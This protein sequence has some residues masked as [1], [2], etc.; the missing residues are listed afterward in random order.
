MWNMIKYSGKYYMTDVTADDPTTDRFGGVSHKYL[1]KSYDCFVSEPGNHM[2]DDMVVTGGLDPEIADDTSYDDYFWDD[3]DTSFQYINDAWYTFNGTDWICKY[4]CNGSS[5]SKSQNLIKVSDLYWSTMSGG[6]YYTV[7][8]SL[9]ISSYDDLLIYTNPTKI[10]SYNVTT[11]SIKTLYNPSSEQLA[12]GRVYGVNVRSDGTMTYQI[13]TSPNEIGNRYSIEIYSE[14]WCVNRVDGIIAEVTNSSMTEY[15]KLYAVTR[16]VAENTDYGAGADILALLKDEKG[17]CY[18]STALIKAACLR[19]GIPAGKRSGANDD[20]AIS[21]DHRNVIAKCDGKYYV[22]DAGYLGNRPRAFHVEEMPGGFTYK[23]IQSG[24][25]IVQYDGFENDI[26]IPSTY[27]GYPVTEFKSG[28]MRLGVTDITIPASI[29]NVYEDELNQ[30]TTLK[31]VTVDSGNSVYSSCDDCLYTKDGTKL[32]VYPKKKTEFTFPSN[33]TEIGTCAFRGV[34]M[35]ILVIPGTVKKIDDNAFL[36]S[37]ISSLTIADG[38]ESIGE[39]AF[40]GG[41]YDT[42]VFNA[43]TATLSAGAFYNIGTQKI[44]LPNGITEIPENAFKNCWYTDEFTIPASV[45]KIG[46]GAFDKCSG[47]IYFQGSEEQWNNLVAGITLPDTIQVN[48]SSI[49][50]T[51]VEFVTEDVVLVDFGETKE[52][53]ARVLPLNASNKKIEYTLENNK[54]EGGVDIV[55]MEGNTIKAI[56]EGE[57]KVVATSEDGEFMAELNVTVR[58]TRFKIK[59]D[60]AVLNNQ[61]EYQGMSEGE[62]KKGQIIHVVRVDEAGYKHLKWQCDQELNMPYGSLDDSSP[63][64]DFFMPKGDVNLKAVVEPIKISTLYWYQKDTYLT[65]M[66]VGTQRKTYYSVTPQNALNQ[67]VTYESADESIATV[68]ENGVITGVAP[69]KV[70][71]TVRAADGGNA[72]DTIDMT[73]VDH[74]WNGGTVTKEPAYPEDGEKTFTCT[75]CGKTRIEIIP[76]TKPDDGDDTE[77]KTDD[78]TEDDTEGNTGENPGGNTDDNTHGKTEGKT[79]GNTQGNTE[80]EQSAKAGTI[81][82]DTAGKAS[83]KVTKA[84]AAPEVEYKCS[85]KKNAAS[86]VVPETVKI[87]GVT[88]KVTSIAAKAFYKNKNLKK[89]T[90]PASVVKIGKQAFF[91]CKNLKTITIKTKKLTS[92]S[93]GAKAFK[94]T[95][96]KA[97]VKTPAGKSKAYKKI[98]RK[99]G[100]SKKS[101]VK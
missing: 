22:A 5:W 100:L 11:G 60:G 6:G 68:D 70:T 42:F 48:C 21:S 13:A 53:V 8:Q 28:G 30:S 37:S 56:N 90:I 57:C 45:T 86:V 27:N 50:V 49:R 71:L 46:A 66:C 75:F 31:S 20:G 91:G 41:F 34:K 101:K 26:V 39:S 65:K 15:Q 94:G 3:I 96:K 38:V 67:N 80:A 19:M 97:R 10:V 40:Y 44:A 52:I 1:L 54:T 62:Y 92:K 18:A 78:K 84:G 73:V 7:S 25:R 99:K 77:D 79:E 87:G 95:H 81:I 82:E 12:S 36:N 74:S 58:F 14:D 85:L 32:L 93:I 88:Y 9:E 55:R 69:G 61:D 2:T 63:E 29:I 43:S 16:W 4:T 51:G 98:L 83:Y 47:N 33:V 35:E 24:Y 72:Y 89:I 17:S 64:L 76:A 23:A 59:L